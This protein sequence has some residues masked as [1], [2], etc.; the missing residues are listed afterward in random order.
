MQLQPLK[1]LGRAAVRRPAKCTPNDT[2]CVITIVCE[3][4]ELKTQYWQ[5]IDHNIHCSEKLHMTPSF[6]YFSLLYPHSFF[7]VYF[8]LSWITSILV[9]L[10]LLYSWQ[11]D[12]Y[13]WLVATFFLWFVL[14]IYFDNI[15]PNASGV[16]KSVFY[17]LNP[18]YWMGK[19][20]S[21]V[22]G[23]SAWSSVSAHEFSPLPGIMTDSFSPL[24]RR[25][26]W[27]L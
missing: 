9:I 27:H 8:N 14:A 22:K 3:D 25:R 20:R 21:K 23:N 7:S 12:I 4:F 17:F 18:W 24:S 15:I 16:R 10:C 11:D 19:G 13:K 26:G 5:H 2:E 1:M 6:L